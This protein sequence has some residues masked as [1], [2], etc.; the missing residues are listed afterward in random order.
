M[1]ICYYDCVMTYISPLLGELR[2]G[3]VSSLQ[4]FIHLLENIHCNIR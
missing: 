2:V 1:Q 4:N 3:P